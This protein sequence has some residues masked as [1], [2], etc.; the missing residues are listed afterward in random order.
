MLPPN[1]R[2][3]SGLSDLPDS[4][5]SRPAFDGSKDVGADV[6][7]VVE[8]E[9]RPS[10]DRFDDELLAG[11]HGH[12]MLIDGNDT[13]GIDVGIMTSPS[14]VE[15]TSMRSSVEEPDRGSAGGASVQPG[16]PRIPM[17]SPRRR[18]RLG[19]PESLQEPIRWWWGR[20]ASTPGPGVRNIV[21]ELIAVGDIR[22]VLSSIS[23]P[24][25]AFYPG[26]RPGSFRSCGIRNRLDYILLSD[27]LA[28]LVESGGIERHGLLGGPPISIP[29]AGTS[30]RKSRAQYTQH[31]TML[32]SSST[33]TSRFLLQLRLSLE[34]GR[35]T[36]QEKR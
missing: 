23:T 1:G 14:Q 33:S 18:N 6:L 21:D 32:P 30:T 10:L 36:Q 20:E 25:P 2:F 7:S 19:T 22:T 3:P 9:D 5:S 31:Q 13:R 17:P 16:L 15:I 12:V 28:G 35:S 8:A 26:P 34:A 27:D 11:N 24:L 29:R 4:S